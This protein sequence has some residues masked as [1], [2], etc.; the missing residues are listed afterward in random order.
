METGR[1][2]GFVVSKYGIQID[3]LKIVVIVALAPPNEIIE[4]QSLQGKE[5]FL[6]HFICNFAEKTHGYMFLLR[7]NTLLIWDDQSQ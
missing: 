5:N 3:P 2:L 4:L 7:K 6:R 1:L